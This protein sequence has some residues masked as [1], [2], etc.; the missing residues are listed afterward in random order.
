[1]RRHIRR[2]L[3][4]SFETGEIAKR[5]GGRKY[6]EDMREKEIRKSEPTERCQSKTGASQ[7]IHHPRKLSPDNFG[8]IGTRGND[9]GRTYKY[10]QR[11]ERF[12]GYFEGRRMKAKKPM[13]HGNEREDTRSKD[14]RLWGP[15]RTPRAYMSGQRPGGWF[16]LLRKKDAGQT[17]A[18]PHEGGPWAI[19]CRTYGI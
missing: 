12:V 18:D 13:S 10:L 14:G 3:R 19:H 7:I 6:R 17:T 5:V 9:D 4:R 11:G 16:E 15:Q 2:S 8:W 1:L